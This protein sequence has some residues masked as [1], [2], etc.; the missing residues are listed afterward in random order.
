MEIEY[1]LSKYEYFV[2]LGYVVII[3]SILTMIITQIIKK[4]LQKKKVITKDTNATKVDMILTK[5]GRIVALLT[6]TLLY[7]GN[8]L[9]LKNTIVIDKGLIAGLLSGSAL[10]LTIAKG[11]YTS[12]HQYF[13]KQEVFKLLEE[14]KQVNKWII[15]GRSNE[16]S[17][18]R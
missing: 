15:R 11:I 2:S 14:D 13:K 9:I 16:E 7:L 4:I 5:I 3:A 1:Y 12:L 6:Y 17:S 10:T 18:N 8:E